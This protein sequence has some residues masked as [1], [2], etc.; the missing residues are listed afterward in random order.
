MPLFKKEFGKRFVRY[1]LFSLHN[2]EMKVLQ[3]EMYLMFN[4]DVQL[5]CSIKMR[6]AAEVAWEDGQL[7]CSTN[8]QR[9]IEMFNCDA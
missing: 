3:M 5:R 6:G 2:Q 1:S 8:I 4:Q 7:R 9:S